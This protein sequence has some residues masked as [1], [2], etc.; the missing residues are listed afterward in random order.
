MY[1]PDLALNN[2]QWLICHKAQSNETK[3]D[4]TQ[5]NFQFGIFLLNYLVYV[6]KFGF[7]LRKNIILKIDII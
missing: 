7:E 2:L 1:K 3:S 4:K 5:L 6:I